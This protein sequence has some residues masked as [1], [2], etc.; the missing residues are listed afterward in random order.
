[1]SG[2][3]K[4]IWQDVEEKRAWLCEKPSIKVDVGWVAVGLQ[5]IK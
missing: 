1:M 3:K 2:K 5:Q 4:S